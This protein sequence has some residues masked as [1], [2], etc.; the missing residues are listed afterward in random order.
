MEDNKD[1]TEGRDSKHV[2]VILGKGLL[3]QLQLPGEGGVGG[4][5]DKLPR[6]GVVARVLEDLQLASK[7]SVRAEWIS[8]IYDRRQQLNLSN[9][10]HVTAD[11]LQVGDDLFHTPAEL[12]HQVGTH[13]GGA[14]RHAGV[15]K[16][17]E[18]S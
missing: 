6:V 14:S 5:V 12:L 11:L 15:A 3:L 2:T 18:G 10:L 7:G 9:P 1:Y 16:W 4:E 13:D 8:I 17:V